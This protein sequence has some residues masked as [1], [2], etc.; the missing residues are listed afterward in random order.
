VGTGDVSYTDGVVTLRR[1]ELSDLPMHMSAVDTEQIDWLWEPGDRSAWE[2][3]TPAGQLEH[4]RRHVQRVHDAF[5][6]GPKWC[7]SV[8]AAESSYVVY[9][10]CD[11]AN[12][13]VPEGQANISYTCHPDHRGKGYTS[14]AVRL[15]C[16]FLRDH[17]SAD[18]AH[19]VVDA[20]NEPSLRVARGVGADL[21]GPF[22]DEHGRRM[23]RHVLAL[24]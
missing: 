13:H 10:D 11:L 12:P 5:G 21:V 18:E 3:L 1:Q 16:A 20:R 9:I 19:I 23:L 2:S 22:V 6:A 7:F 24:R 8:D 15:V 4:Q 17:T 14:R